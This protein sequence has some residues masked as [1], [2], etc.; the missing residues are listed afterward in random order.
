MKFC[1]VVALHRFGFA[2][3]WLTTFRAY[4]QYSE[5]Y[6]DIRWKIIKSLD[7]V[8]F[9]PEKRRLPI[10]PRAP[11]FHVFNKVVKEPRRLSDY[12]GPEEFKNYLNYKQYGIQVRFEKNFKELFTFFLFTTPSHFYKLVEL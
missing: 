9:P 12:R 7:E 6:P 4:S 5:H 2:P 8:E 3:S 10:L 1:K 11:E